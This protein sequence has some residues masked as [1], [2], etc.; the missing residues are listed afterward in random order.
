MTTTCPSCHV[1]EVPPGHLCPA[2]SKQAQA[3]IAAASTAPGWIARLIWWQ[4]VAVGR[5]IVGLVMSEPI[6]FKLMA[7]AVI[8]LTI[9]WLWLQQVQQ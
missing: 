9:G 3:A 2:C 8:A 6:F 4:L 5:M 7:L 1:Q